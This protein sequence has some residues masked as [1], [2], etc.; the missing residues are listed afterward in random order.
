M[1]FQISQREKSESWFDWMY[2]SEKISSF[3]YWKILFETHKEEKFEFLY[4][5]IFCFRNIS[6]NN[7]LWIAAFE[8]NQKLAKNFSNWLF[9]ELIFF[10]AKNDIVN[11]RF[12][13]D[14]Q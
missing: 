12:F 1:I 5:R 9:Q 4:F 8:I 7:R 13:E 2:Y 11:V 6:L 14:D 10:Y 3:K